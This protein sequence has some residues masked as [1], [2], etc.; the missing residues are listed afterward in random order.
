M[1]FGTKDVQSDEEIERIQPVRQLQAGLQ[2]DRLCRAELCSGIS[3]SKVSPT[4]QY[5]PGGA[6]IKGGENPGTSV[7]KNLGSSKRSF[8][9]RMDMKRKVFHAFSSSN[10]LSAATISGRRTLTETLEELCTSIDDRSNGILPAIFLLAPDG[11]GLRLAAGAKVPPDWGEALENLRLP[12]DARFQSPNGQPGN[13]V[14]MADLR[15][16]TSFADCWTLALGKDFRA[17]WSVPIFATDR[18]VLGAL[19]LFCLNARP[20]S[21][22]DLRLVQATIHSA[23]SAIEN[24]LREEVVCIAPHLDFDDDYTEKPVSCRGMIGESLAMR[25]VYELVEKVSQ[26][27]CSVLILGET[28]TGKELVARAIHYSGA[29]REGPFIPVDCSALIPTLIEAELFGYVRGAFTGATT[30]KLGLMEVANQ[31]TLFLDEIGDLPLD[32]QSKFLRVLQEREIRPVGSTQSVPLSA[33]II[34]ATNRNLEAD[35]RQGLFRR[36]LYFRLNVVQIKLPPLRRRLTDIPALARSFVG[37]FSESTD[38]PINISDDGIRC[39]MAYDWP[40]NVRE[41]ANL[42][43]RA[44]ALG[45][46]PSLSA[47]DFAPSIEAGKAQGSPMEDESLCLER[48]IRHKVLEALSE[49]AGNRAEA[50]R[51]LGIGKTTLYRK[52]KTYRAGA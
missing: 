16:D 13:A 36:D 40:G 20:P 33:R 23:A 27:K 47:S 4:E 43:E 50:A 32:M 10:G 45:L 22:H 46:G 12:L 35:V 31:G 1:I 18:G 41:L 17:A 52:L 34:A 37:K 48:H 30:S 21:E 25:P 14:W 2:V 15:N 9:R 8:G 11:R 38:D 42:I 19:V 29:R 5:I 6:C 28:G 26:Q 44:V 7:A 3:L 24:C 39:L 51:A 49:T